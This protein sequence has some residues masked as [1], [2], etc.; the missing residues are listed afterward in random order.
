MKG[1]F[2]FFENRNFVE[3]SGIEIIVIFV[4]SNFQQ[5]GKRN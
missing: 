5:Q 4:Y 2:L 1:F 3:I